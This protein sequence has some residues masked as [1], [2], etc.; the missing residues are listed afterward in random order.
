MMKM[1]FQFAECLI[2]F[3]VRMSN[4]CRSLRFFCSYSLLFCFKCNDKLFIRQILSH[5]YRIS[6][7][8]DVMEIGELY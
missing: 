6:G 7:V 8:C 3:M 5:K 2:I 4:I 1:E